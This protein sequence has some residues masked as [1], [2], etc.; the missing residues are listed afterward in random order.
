MCIY[1]S[2]RIS[3]IQ[4]RF[5]YLWSVIQFVRSQIT[6]CY[7]DAVPMFVNWNYVYSY[8]DVKLWIIPRQIIRRL[9]KGTTSVSQHRGKPLSYWC[10]CTW[11]FLKDCFL[12]MLL[13]VGLSWDVWIDFQIFPW[14]ILWI[15]GC[16]LH[17]HA[18]LLLSN[19]ILSLHRH[20]LH[21]WLLRVGWIID[22]FCGQCARSSVCLYVKRNSHFVLSKMK[23]KRTYCP[24]LPAH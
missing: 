18:I 14:I 22:P 15:R 20:M 10:T 7:T 23:W 5:A 11:C 21:A 17:W 16:L 24:A 6:S 19:L 3:V 8:V 1:F 2:F 13:S 4:I 12:W 9:F